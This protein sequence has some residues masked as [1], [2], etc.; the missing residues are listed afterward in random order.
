MTK[1]KT[2]IR[3]V[4]CDKC[5]I[6]W[7]ELKN[8][9]TTYSGIKFSISAKAHTGDWGGATYSY[10]LCRNCTFKFEKFMVKEND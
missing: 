2:E 10:D 7:D 4:K 9:M 8:D 3:T 1:T 5:K 6:E